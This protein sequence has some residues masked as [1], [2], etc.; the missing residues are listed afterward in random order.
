M[1]NILTFLNFLNEKV[2]KKEMFIIKVEEDRNIFYFKLH[3]E[4]INREI[5]KSLTLFMFLIAKYLKN[6]KK[7]E[8]DFFIDISEVLNKFENLSGDSIP[9][10]NSVIELLNTIFPDK[11]IDQQKTETVEKYESFKKNFVSYFEKT[12]Q[13]ILNFEKFLNY[14][15]DFLN[16]IV[17]TNENLSKIIEL[18][19]VLNYIDSVYIKKY[20]LND[21]FYGNYKQSL[22]LIRPKNVTR[23]FEALDYDKIDPDSDYK[24]DFCKYKLV[25]DVNF[26]LNFKIENLNL[27]KIDGIDMNSLYKYIG[28]FLHYIYIYIIS[29]PNDN[30]KDFIDKHINISQLVGFFGENEDKIKQLEKLLKPTEY[31]NTIFYKVFESLLYKINK[32]IDDLIYKLKFEYFVN[33][34]NQDYQTIGKNLIFIL[35]RLM[36]YSRY[37]DD[38]V[39][40]ISLVTLFGDFND[41]PE[42]IQIIESD[43]IYIKLELKNEETINENEYSGLIGNL[44]MHKSEEGDQNRITIFIN[45]KHVSIFEGITRRYFYAFI[46]KL[47]YLSI[48]NQYLNNGIWDSVN[49]EI[50]VKK[51]NHLNYLIKNKENLFWEYSETKFEDIEA[52]KKKYGNDKIGN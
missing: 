31:N 2:N 27:L 11:N 40:I 42:D 6:K 8:Y 13:N 48:N 34:D 24:I 28:N 49:D 18:F 51:E 10:K 33:F 5:S 32:K 22:I 9:Y 21:I 26:F 41:T 52:L 17:P 39:F 1:A 4:T 37:D 7:M 16:V 20:E 30:F 47:F 12:K 23:V 15:N 3:S 29:K 25:K 19:S 44:V 36:N 50:V 46:Y 43:K 35:N 45:K 38:N 14:F